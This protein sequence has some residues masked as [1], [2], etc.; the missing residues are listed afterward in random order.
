M[1]ISATD[2][3]CRPAVAIQE[4]G[5]LQSLLQVSITHDRKHDADA[6]TLPARA[7]AHAPL[8]LQRY[9]ADGLLFAGF[10]LCASSPKFLPESTQVG[11]TVDV[12]MGKG[13]LAVD[14]KCEMKHI[15]IAGSN[16][17]HVGQIWVCPDLQMIYAAFQSAALSDGGPGGNAD[18]KIVT[19]YQLIKTEWG[20]NDQVVHVNKYMFEALKGLWT[21]EMDGFKGALIKSMNDNPD[22][23]VLFIGNSKGGVLAEMVGLRFAL[24]DDSDRLHIF[25]TGAFRW[26]GQDASALMEGL[27]GERA[28]HAALAK[29][30]LRSSGYAR[31]TEE[32]PTPFWPRAERYMNM[33][34]CYMFLTNGQ[35]APMT[36]YQSTYNSEIPTL[37]HEVI[38]PAEKAGGERRSPLGT[39]VQ[40]VRQSFQTINPAHQA[41]KVIQKVMDIKNMK[42]LHQLTAAIGA[43]KVAAGYKEAS[44]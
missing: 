14:S 24:E 2:S 33:P 12:R 15:T 42:T 28:A 40:A 23:E 27:Y 5:D 35:I 31:V 3:S 18:K 38:G 16:A 6:N 20:K 37:F 29:G 44:K 30:S 36:P 11:H 1:P 22:F 9:M 10:I 32:D 41:G 43:S 13:A 34:H 7:R 4:P 19:E 17:H 21:D 39:V 26:M 8:W 25:S